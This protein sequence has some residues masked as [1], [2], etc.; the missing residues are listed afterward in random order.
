MNGNSGCF[1]TPGK[2]AKSQ[3]R[4]SSPL[5]SAANSLNSDSLNSKSHNEMFWG[6]E[7]DIVVLYNLIRVGYII[8]R[9]YRYLFD[10]GRVSAFGNG[11]EAPLKGKSQ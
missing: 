2:N 1:S 8:L 5:S 7:K 9:N 3:M 10:A 6:A 4:P 11:G